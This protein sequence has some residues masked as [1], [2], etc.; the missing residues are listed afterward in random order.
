M[1]RFFI[2]LSAFLVLSVPGCNKDD[3]N[4]SLQPKQLELPDKADQVIAQSNAF[5]FELFRETALEE[6]DKNLMLSPLSASVA[7]TMLLN[8]CQGDTYDQIRHL[9][10]YEGLTSDEINSTYQSLTEQLLSVDPDVELALGNAVWYRKGFSVKQPFL[11]TMQDVFDS[12]VEALD[13]TQPSALDIINGWASDNTNGKIKKVL[14]EISPD[15]AMFLMNALYFKGMWT[16]QFKKENTTPML[17]YNDNGNTS[18]VETM[19]GNIPSRSYTGQDYQAIELYYGR[20]NFS[21]VII[22]PNTSVDDLL[23]GFDANAWAGLT[24]SLDDLQ[25]DPWETELMVPKFTFEYE[26]LL[27]DQL[28]A[29]GMIDAFDPTR[30]DLTGISDE[31]IYVDFVK[32]NTFINVDEEGTEAAAVTTIGINYT[33]IPEPFIIN[34]SFLFAIRERTTNTLMFVGKVMEP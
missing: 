29:M 20:Q 21:M 34:K 10:G 22:V 8:G 15:A 13:F 7:L 5:G 32:Q 2:L 1:K 26:K 17:F 9:L 16:W 19:T 6:T 30:A 11:A 4:A 28:K 18:D 12:H 24:A 3:N 31:D 14:S 33:S 27:N 25:G 23:E